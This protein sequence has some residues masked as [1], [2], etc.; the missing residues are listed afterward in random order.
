MGD[1]VDPTYPLVHPRP[2][3]MSVRGDGRS[4]EKSSFRRGRK[5]RIELRDEEVLRKELV[6]TGVGG[7]GRRSDLRKNLGY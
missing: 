7:G 2:F 6:V 1:V 4:E 5:F 3:S